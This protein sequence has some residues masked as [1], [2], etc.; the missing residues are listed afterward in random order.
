MPDKQLNH[1]I[2]HPE[3]HLHNAAAEQADENFWRLMKITSETGKPLYLE[4]DG[5]YI[6]SVVE[7]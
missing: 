3:H 7:G 4:D 1:T 5:V 6:F 2:L